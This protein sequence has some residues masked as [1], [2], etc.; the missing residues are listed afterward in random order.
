[1]FWWYILAGLFGG[2]CGGMGMGGGTLLIPTLTMILGVDQHLAQAINLLVFI[3]TGI[4]ALVIHAKNKLLDYR[5]FFVIIIPAIATAVCTALLVGRI[6][7]D[8]LGLC[9]GIF[10]ILVGLYELYCAIRASVE[11]KRKKPLLKSTASISK[12]AKN[13]GVGSLAA[14]VQKSK[15]GKTA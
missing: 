11:S 3:P 6:E 7:S 10:L 5:V 14:S 8:V 13:S 15:P 2:I 4:A 9:F 12:I 1:M